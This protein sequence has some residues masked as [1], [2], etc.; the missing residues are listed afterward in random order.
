MRN[1]ARDLV[2]NS[3]PSVRGSLQVEELLNKARFLDEVLR[4][5]RRSVQ[6][7]LKTLKRLE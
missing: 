1:A 2:Q 3:M 5:A 7:L 6:H 4:R